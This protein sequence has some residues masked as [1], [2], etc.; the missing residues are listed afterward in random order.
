MCLS[1]I[2]IDSNGKLEEVMKDVAGIE[3]RDNGFILTDLF[4][5]EKFVQGKLQSA[6]FVEG[7][8]VLSH[9]IT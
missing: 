6:D 8:S 1:T 9:N 5:E 3:A 4:G 7:R 2:Y